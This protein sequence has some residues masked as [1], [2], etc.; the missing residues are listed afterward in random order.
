MHFSFE[1][2][3]VRISSLARLISVGVLL[4]GLAICAAAEPP[5]PKLNEML[6]NELGP[7]H[8]L[9]SIRPLLSLAR[10]GVLKPEVFS[11]GIDSG[12]SPFL[13]A[14]TEYLSPEGERLSV[15]ILRFNQDSEAYSLLTLIAKQMHE[16]GS[17][18][19]GPSLGSVGIATAISERSIAFFKGTTFVRITNIGWQAKRSNNLMA[20]ARLFAER[21]DKGEG[22]VPVLL[23]HLPDWEKAMGTSI[24]LVSLQPL[25]DSLSNQ[26]VLQA[27]SFEGGTEA[28]AASYGQSQLLL[29]EFTTPQLATENDK[30]IV[31]KIRELTNPGQPVPSAYRRVGNY[32][33]FVFNAA[34]AQTA[35]QL[36]DQVKYEQVVRWLGDNPNILKE[37]QRKYT[38]TTMG[39]FIAVVKA[40]GLA[41]LLCFGIGGVFG[42]LLFAKRR[43]QQTEQRAYSD[44]GGMMRLNIDEM[45]PKIDPA[46]LIGSG[47][48]DKL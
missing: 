24:Y 45:T 3:V 2:Q 40:S 23:K 17:A 44:A 20:L 29:V 7:F 25:K 32:S 35:N 14:A 1:L 18:A 11:A 10:G 27:I 5:S 8:Q 41:A 12:K 19:D 9:P 16:Q 33:V 21:I 39:V 34:D 28:V 30:R 31:E 6:P 26:A 46:R 43:S 4:I 15:E 42:A 22:D 38:E 48:S 37:A 36:I 47:M 13:G